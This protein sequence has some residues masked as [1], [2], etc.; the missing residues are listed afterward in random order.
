MATVTS[1]TK[2]G[3]NETL[4]DA[5]K[6]T[7]SGIFSEFLVQELATAATDNHRAEG[8]DMTDTGITNLSRL[9]NYHQISTRGFIISGTVEQVD[10]AGIESEVALN[11]NGLTLH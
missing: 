5:S 1:I 2:V 10:K 11:Y 8:A 9:G 3:E 7:T 4:A 6:R